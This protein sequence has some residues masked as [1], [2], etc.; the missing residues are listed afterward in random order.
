MISRLLAVL[1]GSA[2][3]STFAHICDSLGSSK[4]STCL[5]VEKVDLT[6]RLIW[7][8]T[9]W[10]MWSVCERKSWSL[11]ISMRSHWALENI[12]SEWRTLFSPWRW[13]LWKLWLWESTLDGGE[14]F[15]LPA[16]LLCSTCFCDALCRRNDCVRGV[17][18]GKRPGSPGGR[19][20]RHWNGFG[21]LVT[22]LEVTFIELQ[23]VR[24]WRSDHH[25]SLSGRHAICE[26]LRRYPRV[27][28]VSCRLLGKTD[29]RWWEIDVWACLC[30]HSFQEMISIE[31]ETTRNLIWM[32]TASR[33]GCG[34]RVMGRGDGALWEAK[35]S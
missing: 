1:L 2:L 7:R 14:I 5:L 11:V 15:G 25:W 19:R 12:Y 13:E 32:N 26:W 23:A 16:G 33:G 17:W 22:L 3:Y 4:L 8:P 29:W 9:R 21:G 6:R 18:W 10:P 27:V 24:C 20:F 30:G 28:A 35:P 34:L 31:R